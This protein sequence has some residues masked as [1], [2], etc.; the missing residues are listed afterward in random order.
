VAD[1]RDAEDILH[2]IFL[3]IQQ[4]LTGLKANKKMDAWIYSITRNTITDHYR[5]NRKNISASPEY[6]EAD[7]EN[8]QS[9]HD[10]IARCLLPLT[11]QLPHIYREALILSQFKS[12]THKEIADKLGLSVSGVKSRVQRGRKLLK[13][14]LLDCCRF[15]LDRTNRIV[16]YENRQ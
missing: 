15:E 11:A 7:Q 10:E 2:D 12:M 4:G 13:K 5:R 9:A 16:D 14:I 6:F 8:K 3:K 1:Q